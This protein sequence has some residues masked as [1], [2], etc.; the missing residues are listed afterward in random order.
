[1]KVKLNAAT[2]LMAAEGEEWF[3]SLS[4]EQQ[5]KYLKLH[6]NSSYGNGSHRSEKG[7]SEAD[8]ERMEHLKMHI[9]HL[10][11]DVADMDR[12]GDDASVERK[13]LS[14]AQ[15]ELNELLRK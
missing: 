8:S 6:P 12:E 11:E 3:K 10:T 5:D 14:D 1:M 13:Q 9:R 7:M 2:R 4:K 15:K